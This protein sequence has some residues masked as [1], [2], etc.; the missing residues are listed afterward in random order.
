MAPFLTAEWRA[1]VIANFEVAPHRLA[2]LTPAGTELDL[3][4]GRALVSLVGFEFLQ[5][6]VFGCQIPGHVNFEE[7]NL[8]FYVR[9]VGPDGLMRRGV[10]FLKELV[11]RR[12]I[13]WVARVAYQEP[14][15]A[16]RMDHAWQLGL[17]MGV[18]FRL[19]SY[20]WRMGGRWHRLGAV[21]DG[22]PAL[23]VP[24]SQAEFTVEHY[25]GY[26][27]QRDGS[28]LEYSVQHAPWRVW[29]A[30]TAILELDAGLTYGSEWADLLKSPPTAILIAEGSPVA[31][32]PGQRLSP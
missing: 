30:H 3:F 7:V 21:A 19:A 17:T 8:R 2:S 9:R 15:Q 14:Y 18:Q 22:E 6:R 31:V 5:T 11:P 28:T 1:L 25:W 20:D 27:A 12:L 13:A 29:K 24:G 26:T 10:V 23:P 4:E 32:Y 16:V